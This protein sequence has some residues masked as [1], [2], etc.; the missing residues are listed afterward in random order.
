MSQP[1]SPHSPLPD[2]QGALPRRLISP[3]ERFAPP[4]DSNEIPISTES[5]APT[6]SVPTEPENP[7]DAQISARRRDE[8]ERRHTAPGERARQE[9]ARLRRENLGGE[10]LSRDSSR[11]APAV[12]NQPL[13]PDQ[14]SHQQR[15]RAERDFAQGVRAAAPLAPLA[16]PRRRRV[17][18]WIKRLFGLVVLL[19]VGQLVFAMFTAPQFNIESVEIQGIV[20]TPPDQLRPL[21]RALVGQN[22]LRMKGKSV[23]IAAELL[24][25]V[26]HA[27]VVRLTHWPPKVALQITERHPVLKVGAGQDWWVVDQKGVPFRRPTTEDEALY[28]V[29]APQFSPQL[30]RPLE[31]RLWKR[32]LAL[33]GALEADNRLA[34]IKSQGAGANFWQLRRIYFDRDGLASLRLDFAPHREMLVRIGDDAYAEKLARA[35][36]SLAYFE[37]TRRQ[38][39]ELDLV[40]LQRPVWKQHEVRNLAQ[41]SRKSDLNAG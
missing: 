18:R 34:K 6:E 22:L 41:N 29:V 4:A 27:K 2:D 39:T 20:A 14:I 33:H 15:A 1:P 8:M 11:R 17:P 23:E 9:R 16:P 38:A 13:S 37:R 36:Q 32:A 35:R 30:R 26:D 19:F 3:Q 21:A 31:P 40:S 28:S 7:F 10:N 5:Q 12:S 25:T 24:P